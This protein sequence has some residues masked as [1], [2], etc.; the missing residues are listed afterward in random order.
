V[1]LKEAFSQLINSKEYKD[2]S[3]GQESGPK[4]Y[5]TYISRFNSGEL[6]SGAMVEMLHAHG[7]EI[8]AR[9]IVKKK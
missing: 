1:T 5:R 7:Y 8:S 9:R 2:M 3:K 4:K 6:K